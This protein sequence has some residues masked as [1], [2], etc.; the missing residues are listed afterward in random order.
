MT[1]AYVRGTQDGGMIATV[2]HFPGHG[3]TEAD[4]H[5]GSANVN[6]PR[7]EF[8][9][10]DLRPFRAALDAGVLSVMTGHL[11]TPAVDKSN[12]PASISSVMTTDLLRTTLGF[13]GL[14]VTD[15]MN[16][17]AVSKRY[18][19]DEAAV[20]AVRA[21][22]DVI[23]MPP[24]ADGAIDAIVRA[25]KRGDITEHRIDESVRRILKAKQWAGLDTNRLTN[26][27]AVSSALGISAHSALAN[28]IARKS[29]TVLGNATNLLPVTL[30]RKKRILDVAFSEKEDPSEGRTFHRAIRH[31]HR[32]TDY[33]KI[34]P[35]SNDMEY[36][37][38][39]EKAKQADLLFLHF[40]IEAHS[41]PAYLPEK[42]SAVVRK[43]LALNKSV[44]ALSFGS[45]Y[46]VLEFP[47]VGTYVC[48]YG[49]SRLSI[50]AAADVL[51]GDQPALGKLP[52]AIP[53][54]YAYGDGV[55][56]GTI[57]GLRVGDPEEAG[58]IP[59]T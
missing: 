11:S 34:D 55:I 19:N 8:E 1:A 14:V 15:A 28:E 4:T 23:L 52:V 54:L 12:A 30:A 37:R 9:K 38:L 21:G 53:G 50:E 22:N 24:D 41:R 47:S 25:V 31:Y 29:V 10:N 16:M 20:M 6:V 51:F 57:A 44:V 3:A 59:S 45:P 49:P 13:Q 42:I 58:L 46:I 5:L 40:Y 7:E 56:Y 43:L 17:R 33:M 36:T 35:R 27:D 48:T 32:A 39:L 26:I 2:K 18:S